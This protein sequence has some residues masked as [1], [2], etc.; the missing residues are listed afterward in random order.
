MAQLS[1]FDAPNRMLASVSPQRAW[2]QR[3]GW[4]R[5]RLASFFD[6]PTNRV[7]LALECHSRGWLYLL[8]AAIPLALSVSLYLPWLCRYNCIRD[9]P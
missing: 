5:F 1:L 2:L 7:N 3:Y 6:T 8:D 4:K 9:L